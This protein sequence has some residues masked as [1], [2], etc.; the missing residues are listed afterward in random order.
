MASK[1]VEQAQVH[2]I[3][4]SLNSGVVNRLPELTWRPTL[5][6]NSKC[7]GC[8]FWK[9]E[10][11][12]FPSKRVPSFIDEMHQLG[13]AEVLFIGGEPTLHADFPRMVSLLHEREIRVVVFTNALVENEE[14]KQVLCSGVNTLITSLDSPDAAVHN[15]L[16]GR[17]DA[18]A[19][20][21]GLLEE[22]KRS[23]PHTFLALNSVVSAA[24]YYPGFVKDFVTLAKALGIG[25][26]AF[27]L[28]DFRLSSRQ[29]PNQSDEQ[30]QLSEKDFNHFVDEFIAMS[31]Q[32]SEIIIASN[33]DVKMFVEGEPGDA[34]A[35][36]KS[37]RYGTPLYRHLPCWESW[38]NINVLP[39]GDCY[40]CL[41]TILDQ[42]RL[43]GNVLES[44]LESVVRGAKAI[45]YRKDRL[46][47]PL[48]VCLCCKDH[49]AKNQKLTALA[50]PELLSNERVFTLP[51]N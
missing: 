3:V 33:P 25:Y 27:S 48:G 1:H 44:N 50:A 20:V 49:Q 21:T 41:S 2:N 23:S 39:N 29:R 22:L 46:S 4:T 31:N 8:S 30:V 7:T 19:A 17:N 24:N 12:S 15:R 34:Y 14:A 37:G 42:R 16:R 26:M 45:K 43:L 36:Y 32:H 28:M 10:L 6:C 47:H 35:R 18:Y 11:P 5:N 51:R 38:N 40:P 9:K 13:V